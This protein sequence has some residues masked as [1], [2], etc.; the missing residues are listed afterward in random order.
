M[1]DQVIIMWMKIIGIGLG[2]FIGSVIIWFIYD[3][4]RVSKITKRFK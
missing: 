2:I 1:S 3:M 4:Q